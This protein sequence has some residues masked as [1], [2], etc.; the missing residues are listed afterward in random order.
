MPRTTAMPRIP[1]V[2]SPRSAMTSTTM[3]ARASSIDV[4]SVMA[5]DR[6][7]S[8]TLHP[9]NMTHQAPR[10][11]ERGAPA[12]V[13]RSRSAI[14]RYG[15]SMFAKGTSHHAIDQPGEIFGVPPPSH[16]TFATDRLCQA[17]NEMPARRTVTPLT[18]DQAVTTSA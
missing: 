17:R 2:A 15:M 9:M 1:E 3:S 8:A 7:P 13:R 14:E 6:M 10:R 12:A 18:S 16:G 5:N 4:V 11:R